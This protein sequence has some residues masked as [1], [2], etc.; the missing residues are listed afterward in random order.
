VRGILAGYGDLTVLWDVSIDVDQGAFVAV[1]G[2]NGAGKTTLMKSI[3]GIVRPTQGTISFDGKTLD[4]LETYQRVRLGLSLVPERVVLP[5]M[6]V[7]ENIELGAFRRDARAHLADSL[8]FVF[9]LFP[10]LTERAKQAAGTLSGGE[11]QMV[12]IARALVGRPQLL[13][14]DEPSAGLAPRLVAQILGALKRLN[15]DGITVL[16]VEQNVAQTL[17]LVTHAYVL[18]TGRVAKSGR[19]QDLLADVSVQR[20]YLGV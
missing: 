16:L 8:S 20:A 5:R 11:Q 19:G 17:K 15:D 18:D 6:T 10:A 4:G 14:L 13:M 9:D 2:S 7:R 12:C 3:M 1:I